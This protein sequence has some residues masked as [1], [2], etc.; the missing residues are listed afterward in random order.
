MGKESIHS[1]TNHQVGVLVGKIELLTNAIDSLS[2]RFEEHLKE[3][4]ATWLWV[5]PTLLSL[6]TFIFMMIVYWGNYGGD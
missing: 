5:F 3:H 2:K 6:G 1:T 4:R